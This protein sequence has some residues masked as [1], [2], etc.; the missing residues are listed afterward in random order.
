MP[1]LDQAKFDEIK[2]IMKEKNATYV[3][4]SYDAKDGFI[5]LTEVA[6]NTQA[7]VKPLCDAFDKSRYVAYTLYP[8]YVGVG[9]ELDSSGNPKE[10]SS[11]TDGSSKTDPNEG[12]VIIK[13][14]TLKLKG[15]GEL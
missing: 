14:L 10:T 2:K 8:G 12:K 6:V 7:E 9:A 13:E 15:T 5:T 3:G 11:A 4:I 1:F